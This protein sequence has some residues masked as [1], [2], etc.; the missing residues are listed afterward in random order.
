MLLGI[1]LIQVFPG[2]LAL[3]AT[4]LMISQ[5]G[6]VIP[7]LDLDTHT[8]LIL[9]YLGGAMGVNTWLMKGFFD[10]IPAEL[11]DVFKQLKKLLDAIRAGQ[12]AGVEIAC[13]RPSNRNL[14][15]AWTHRTCPSGH[16]TRYLRS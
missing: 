15:L 8:S 10:T 1:L 5:M 12:G 11:D 16:T 14:A 4:F 6:D 7:F 3:V 13:P 9:V 2:L